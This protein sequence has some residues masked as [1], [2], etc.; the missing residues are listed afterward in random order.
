MPLTHRLMLQPCDLSFL[1]Q[2]TLWRESWFAW[3]TWAIRPRAKAIGRKPDASSR[4]TSPAAFL[5]SIFLPTISSQG[6]Q[7]LSAP[8]P[9]WPETAAGKAIISTG[10]EGGPEHLS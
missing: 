10:P 4:P 7:V 6:A 3:G 2:A 5:P 1:E 9:P 8:F